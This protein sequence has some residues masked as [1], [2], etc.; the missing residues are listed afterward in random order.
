M[1]LLYSKCEVNRLKHVQV[2]ASG[3][4][5]RKEAEDEEKCKENMTNF[6]GTCLSD[7]W[8]DSTQIWNRRCPTLREFLQQTWLIFVWTLLSYECMKTMFSWSC[9]IHTCLSCTCTSCTW[10]HNTLSCILIYV[11]SCVYLLAAHRFS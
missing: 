8:V 11:T 6:E 4:K 1:L 3:A 7:G 10:P 2:V 9:R 5:R